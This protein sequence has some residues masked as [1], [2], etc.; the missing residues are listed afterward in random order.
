MVCLRFE[1]LEY[2]KFDQDAMV[3]RKLWSLSPDRV[4]TSFSGID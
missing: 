3:L 1:F 4:Y 2:W